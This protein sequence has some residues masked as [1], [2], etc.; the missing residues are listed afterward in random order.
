MRIS[1]VPASEVLMTLGS[2][3]VAD[4][5][6]SDQWSGGPYVVISKSSEAVLLK[7]RKLSGTRMLFKTLNH[8]VR[9]V[10]RI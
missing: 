5:I 10:G 2:A 3:Q 8:P 9:I 7:S 1:N 6:D 4:I